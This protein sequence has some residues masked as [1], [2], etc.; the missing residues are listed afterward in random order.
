MYMR[1]I[2]LRDIKGPV[3]GVRVVNG[4]EDCKEKVSAKVGITKECI[5]GALVAVLLR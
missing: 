5:G 2:R 3:D 4:H 1:F